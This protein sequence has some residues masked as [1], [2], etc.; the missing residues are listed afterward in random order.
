[1]RARLGSDV[2]MLLAVGGWTDSVGDKY[3]RMAATAASRAKFV[4][5][6]VKFVTE[7]GFDGLDVHWSFPGCPQG[8]CQ[9]G[10]AMDRANHALLLKVR[11]VRGGGAQGRLVECAD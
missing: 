1:M 9:D 5:S 8:D 3:S 11:S 10:S 2:E 4:Q 7:N 6:A